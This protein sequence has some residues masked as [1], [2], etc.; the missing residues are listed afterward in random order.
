[1]TKIHPSS[2]ATG[3]GMPKSV[4]DEQ[5]V[6]VL[7]VWKKSL[8]FNCT[9]FTVFNAKGNL[10][11]R[12]DNYI[13]GNKGEIVL[14][15]DAGKSLLTIRRKRLSLVAD[16]WLVYDGET[17]ANPRFSVKKKQGSLSNSKSLAHVSPGCG[18]N[19]GQGN[20]GRGSGS[21]SGNGKSSSDDE[22]KKL[23]YEIEG[24]YAQRCCLIYDESRRCVAEM[25]PKEAVAGVCF[26]VDVFRL[27]VQPE[28]DPTVAMALVILL[29]QMFGSKR[30]SGFNPQ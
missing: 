3:S 16:T 22:K 1:M 28:L 2:S 29:D 21:G 4:S 12:V 23:I 13:S 26:G 17:T 20:G 27:I 19:Q 7:T 25:R 9:G 11:F 5:Q 14:M 8:L 6:V 24:S 15:D 30:F 10:V 18:G